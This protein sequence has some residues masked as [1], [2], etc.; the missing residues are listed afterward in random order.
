[1]HI[2]T[3]ATSLKY[4]T[5]L[6]IG[7]VFICAA[8]N[9]YGGASSA[10]VRL[11]DDVVIERLAEGVWLH[12]SDY[13][14]SG[15][16]NVPANGLLVIDGREAIII[17]LPWTDEQTAVLFGWI[18]DKQNAKV[19]CVIPTHFHI[20][21]A[22][23]LAEA[24]KRKA[25][26]FALDKTVEI[27]K[28]TKKPVPK[29]W[30]AKHMCLGCSSIHVELAYYGAGHTV[31]NI[32]AWIPEKKILFGGCMVKS[33][34]ARNLGNITDADLEEWPKTLKR[35]K[36]KYSNAEI[37]VPGHGRPGGIELIDY[38]INLFKR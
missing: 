36:E 3:R 28:R 24:H 17:D 35:V 32:L 9:V 20:D 14:I 15:L 12:T 31:D 1:M 10:R 18:N 13:D 37:V 2:K 34:R 22:G 21:C 11:S 4:F 33:V 16:Q 7:C 23:G 27:L 25:E 19:K 26:S 30:F 29:N 8:M 6:L 38:T 5:A